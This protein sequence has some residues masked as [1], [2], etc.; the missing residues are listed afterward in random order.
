MAIYNDSVKQTLLNAIIAKNP[1]FAGATVDNVVFGVPVTT[2]GSPNTKVTV[3]GIP[4]KGF[5][6]VDTV[7][8]NRLYISSLFTN[9]PNPTVQQYNAEKNGDLLERMSYL[10][11]LNITE[12]DV[13]TASEPIQADWKS[14]MVQ[15]LFTTS[16][17]YVGSINL[18]WR[19]GSVPQLWETYRERELVSLSVPDLMLRAFQIDFSDSVSVLT[20][21]AENTPLTTSVAGAQALVDLLSTSTG[22]QVVIGGT[23]IPGDGQYDLS[24]FTVTRLA[25]AHL[26]DANTSYSQVVVLTPPT[27][28][29]KQYSAIYL[30]YNGGT[31]SLTAN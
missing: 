23:E 31:D 21:V 26:D 5:T 11:G 15:L 30:H 9:Q 28:F 10:Y 29:G 6:G 17:Q 2:S 4:S 19:R 13:A 3:R 1:A 27:H 25:T 8:Y 22:K 7:N 12:E 20:S 16:L 18:N 24:G 14:K